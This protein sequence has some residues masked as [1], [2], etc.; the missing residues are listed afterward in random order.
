MSSMGSG[1]PRSEKPVIGSFIHLL[2]AR[3]IG[4][5]ALPRGIPG[6]RTCSLPRQPNEGSGF[7]RTSMNCQAHFAGGGR[8]LRAFQVRT[9]A[10][11]CNRGRPWCGGYS[12][13]RSR[14]LARD[15]SWAPHTTASC[16]PVGF[17]RA[18]TTAS[19]TLGL[20]VR[21]ALHLLALYLEPRISL[22]SR[23]PDSTTLSSRHRAPDYPSV[24]A[25][26]LLAWMDSV[27]V[28][29][30]PPSLPGRFL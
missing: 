3:R 1:P 23:A 30:G 15:A 2:P 11:P 10:G 25:A 24:R 28:T 17:R 5:R 14:S 22:E 21:S 29:S 12:P 13:G 19:C 4:G 27:R 9:T 20:G 8:V 26:G 6:G 16:Y 7:G 18:V